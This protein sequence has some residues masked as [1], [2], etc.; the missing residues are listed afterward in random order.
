MPFS[1]SHVELRDDNPLLYNGKSVLKAVSNINN[2]ISPDLKGFEVDDQKNIDNKLLSFIAGEFEK[3][4]YHILGASELI[5]NLTVEPGFLCGSSYESLNRDIFKA[6]SVLRALS[7]EDIGQG[8][9]VENG[10]VLGIETIQGTN[11]L[12]KFVEHTA[13]NLRVK[14][15]GGIFV[16]RPKCDQ[17]LR[18]DLP[19]IGS[20]TITLAC[21]AGLRGLVVSPSSVIILER[22]QCIEIAE[23]NDFFILARDSVSWK[24]S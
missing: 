7:P 10:L 8:I 6:D 18:F 11:E 19:V 23:A 2:I 5:P 12:L 21:Q 9:V 24:Y 13:L 14:G 20:E 1:P 15:Q 17:D 22:S 3:K 4:G 16:K